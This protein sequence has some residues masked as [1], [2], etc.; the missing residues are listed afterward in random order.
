MSEVRQCRV[1]SR[2]RTLTGFWSW[3]VTLVAIG[4]ILY[5]LVR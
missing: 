1:P 5:V 2:D 3:L 4:F